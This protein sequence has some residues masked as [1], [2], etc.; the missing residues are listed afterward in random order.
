MA[1]AV[2]AM[3][4]VMMMPVEATRAMEVASDMAVTATRGGRGGSR[5]Q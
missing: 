2:V 5:G 1:K 3:T 4:M